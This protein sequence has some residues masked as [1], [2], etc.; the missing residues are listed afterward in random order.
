MKFIDRHLPDVA[1]I[2]LFA[3]AQLSDV[4]STMFIYHNIGIHEANPISAAFLRTFGPLVFMAVKLTLPFIAAL[5]LTAAYRAAV[6]H[7]RFWLHSFAFGAIALG[8][9]FTIVVVVGNLLILQMSGAF[10]L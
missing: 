8:A 7:R 9:A 1:V 2:V 6:Q 10:S 5:L 3:A 4:A